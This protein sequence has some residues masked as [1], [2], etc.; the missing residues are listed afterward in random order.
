MNN[1]K[2]AAIWRKKIFHTIQ[3]WYYFK[4][5]VHLYKSVFISYSWANHLDYNGKTKPEHQDKKWRYFGIVFKYLYSLSKRRIML[6]N[7]TSK[8]KFKMLPKKIRKL[9]FSARNQQLRVLDSVAFK[10]QV[11]AVH[12]TTISAHP[13]PASGAM[14]RTKSSA[15]LFFFF[16]GQC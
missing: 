9:I 15:G 7:P 5:N 4:Y 8:E 14:P 1:S 16:L 12:L 11:L 6:G 13:F 3:K 10:F 2:C